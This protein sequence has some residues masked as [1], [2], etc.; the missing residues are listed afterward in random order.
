LSAGKVA[1]VTTSG[2][3]TEY[4]I[5]TANSGPL[6]IAEGPDG[7]MWFTEG[8][9]NRVA[10]VT[11]AGVFTEYVVPRADSGPYGIAAGP[12]GNIWFTESGTYVQGTEVF[13][14]AVA[15]VTTSGVF[16]EY[17][18]PTPS[19]VPQDIAAG[20]D[21]NLWFTET[22]AYKIGK[23]T[24]SG[25]FTEYEAGAANESAPPALRASSPL[26]IAAGPDRNLWFVD[27]TSDKV[28]KITPLGVVTK[29]AIPTANSTPLGIAAGPDRSLWF[30]ETNAN[31]VARILAFPAGS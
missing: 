27:L 30:T 17:I 21:G 10:N 23:V 1:K 6:G 7:N 4:T 9:A 22:A 12:D 16:N 3:V 8:S 28:G 14:G 24:T 18:V 29:Y 20:P 19:A 31:Q 5:P 11:I 25:V 26:G 15:K 2:V 13:T